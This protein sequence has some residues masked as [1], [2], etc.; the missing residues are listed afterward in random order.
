MT[1]ISQTKITVRG[2]GVL[3]HLVVSRA[4][5]EK[6]GFGGKGDASMAESTF[7]VY[8]RIYLNAC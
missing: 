7:E 3:P 2:V 6:V 5:E 4:K 8:W 1:K